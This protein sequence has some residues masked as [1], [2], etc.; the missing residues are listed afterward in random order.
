LEHVACDLCGGTKFDEI[1]RQTDIIHHTT[2]EMFYVV[3]CKECGLHFLNPRPNKDEIGRY[4]TSS[5][6]FHATPSRLKL[7]TLSLLTQLVNSPLHHLFNLIPNLN[8]RLASYVKPKIEDPVRRHFRGSR[9]L[10]IGCGS[11]VSAHFWG[12]KGALFAYK[13]FADVYG[14]EVADKAK[15][16]LSAAGIPVYPNLA[17]IPADL[18][19]DIIRMN[20]SLEHVHSPAEYFQFLS[21]KLTETGKAIIAVPNYGGLLYTLARD[22]VE[23]PIHLYHFRKQDLITYANN[24]GLQLIDFTTFS[25]PQMF[26]FA[27]AACP[28]LRRGFAKPMNV[29]EAYFFQKILSRFDASEIGNDM[30]AIL[31]KKDI[32]RKT[33]TTVQTT[34]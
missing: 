10:D 15:D 16:T 17:A 2:D 1:F 5:Y 31:E 20:W 13:K 33:T 7:A 23:V 8:R 29:S 30:I 12:E 25:Y 3:R 21:E 27:A 18:R 19:F 24:V 32:V 6:A 9:I 11:G 28:N 34:T 26:T 4:Y 14:V 22:C